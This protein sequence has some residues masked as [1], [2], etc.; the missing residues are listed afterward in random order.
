MKFMKQELKLL[1]ISYDLYDTGLTDQVFNGHWY[2]Y[3]QWH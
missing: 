1:R 2:H 3:L